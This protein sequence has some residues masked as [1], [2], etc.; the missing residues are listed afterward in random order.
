MRAIVGP[1]DAQVWK[2]SW[3]YRRVASIKKDTVAKI[4]LNDGCLVLLARS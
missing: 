1:E 3:G 2:T 4:N